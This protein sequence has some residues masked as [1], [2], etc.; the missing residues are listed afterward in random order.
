MRLGPTN[1]ALF[2]GG[3][4][5]GVLGCPSLGEVGEAS[6]RTEELLVSVRKNGYE[7][8]E[9]AECL[10]FASSGL[11]F[12]YA[13]A[14]STPRIEPG[15]L[16]VSVSATVTAT[17]TSNGATL[18]LL[19]PKHLVRNT[20]VIGTTKLQDGSQVDVL[21]EATG[22]TYDAGRCNIYLWP[23]GDWKA[24]HLAPGQSVAMCYLFTIAKP[25]QQATKLTVD[26]PIANQLLLQHGLVEDDGDPSKAGALYDRI[27]NVCP[28]TFSISH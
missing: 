24:I 12:Q 26:V 13:I 17:P 5:L 6:D 27:P 21:R 25:S 19:S 3:L 8:P 16:L 7:S 9:V 20:L 15:L 11:S 4:L 18:I 14:T 10:T 23:S 22:S 2:F 28:R 1:R